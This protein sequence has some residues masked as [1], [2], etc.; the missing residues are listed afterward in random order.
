[1]HQM[2]RVNASALALDLREYLMQPHVHIDISVASS[3]DYTA[4]LRSQCLRE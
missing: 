1:M 4:Q 3:Q 2:D